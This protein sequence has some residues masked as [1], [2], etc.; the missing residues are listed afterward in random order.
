MLQYTTLKAATEEQAD[1]QAFVKVKNF[2][3][4]PYG[5]LEHDGKPP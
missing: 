1:L 4:P 5:S 2:K 3:E